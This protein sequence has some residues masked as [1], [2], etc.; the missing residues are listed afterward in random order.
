M[1]EVLFPFSTAKYTS[2]PVEKVEINVTVR[3]QKK[4]KNIYSP[5]HAV[6]IKRPTDRLAKVSF[7]ASN[8]IPTSDFRL[9]YDIGNKKVGASVL[10][11]RPHGD[12]DGYFLL[13]LSPEI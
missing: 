5:T 1:T 11:Y 13:L 10:S 9:M 8:H 7:S 6:E 2:R 4:I 3:S 12:E